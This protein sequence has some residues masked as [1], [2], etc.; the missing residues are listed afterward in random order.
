MKDTFTYV[1][2]PFSKNSSMKI[3]NRIV[4]DFSNLCDSGA[5]RCGDGSGFRIVVISERV[6]VMSEIMD[7][8]NDSTLV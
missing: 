6:D 3:V 8:I 1:S 7:I 5:I 4:T 2:R